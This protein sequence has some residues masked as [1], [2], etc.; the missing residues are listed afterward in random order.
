M[1][2]KN[3]FRMFS[4]R[5]KAIFFKDGQFFGETKVEVLPLKRNV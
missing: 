4:E 1:I 2:L 3:I 5:G